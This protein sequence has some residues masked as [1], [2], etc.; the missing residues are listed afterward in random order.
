MK[1]WRD[2]R[3]RFIKV[4]E[5]NQLSNSFEPA[6]PSTPTLTVCDAHIP[7]QQRITLRRQRKGK[8]EAE[9]QKEFV[10]EENMSLNKS[11]NLNTK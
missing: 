10:R 2:E 8:R 3:D 7:E 11:M 6:T 1:Y 4:I 9:R 5:K